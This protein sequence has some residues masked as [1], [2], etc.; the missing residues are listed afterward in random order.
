MQYDDMLQ[1]IFDIASGEF[2]WENVKEY[3]KII[4]DFVMD[5]FKD[6]LDNGK[7]QFILL[8]PAIDEIPL[9]SICV[10]NAEIIVKEKPVVPNVAAKKGPVKKGPV[11][12]THETFWCE[13]TLLFQT[14]SDKLKI[15]AI[16]KD[17]DR[18]FRDNALECINK[19]FKLEPEKEIMT[20]TL[21]EEYDKFIESLLGQLV[22]R[23][24]LKIVSLDVKQSDEA[25]NEE[26]E[27]DDNEEEKA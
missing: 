25:E 5:R 21:N 23:Y 20:P 19:L 24:H 22:E 13:K 15:I 7:V 12:I 27:K 18:I 14:V 6:S 3:Y 17:F 16:N 8:D 9:N 2:G 4:V 1:L 11:K 26:E 10:V